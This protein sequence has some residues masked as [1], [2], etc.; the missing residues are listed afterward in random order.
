MRGP[1]N[2]GV[3][4]DAGQVSAVLL[5]ETLFGVKPLDFEKRQ[6]PEKHDSAGLAGV[7]NELLQALISRNN[8]RHAAINLGLPE[9]M[10]AFRVIELPKAVKENL[11]GALYYELNEYLP[12]LPD[13][14]YFDC[15]V[16]AEDS[17]TAMIKVLLVVAKKKLLDPL[18]D[19]GVAPVTKLTRIE[20]GSA[21]IGDFL[22]QAGAGGR[23]KPFFV[24]SASG[25]QLIFTVF[26]KGRIRHVSKISIAAGSGRGSEAAAQQMQHVIDE[27]DAAFG[28]IGTCFY[29]DGKPPEA[30]LGL[31]YRFDIETAPIET[32]KF[33]FPESGYI[34]AFGLAADPLG[35]GPNT[36]NLLPES[37]QTR[38]G[39]LGYYALYALAGSLV[40]SAGIYGGSLVYLKKNAI[41]RLDAKIV[42]MEKSVA[43]MER[44]RA[45]YEQVASRLR[46]LKDFTGGAP[47][48]QMLTE[49]SEM[50]PQ[51]TWMTEF[52]LSDNE[53]RIEGFSDSASK[54][55]G[56]LEDSPLFD[57]AR[58]LSPIRKEVNNKERFQIGVE[59]EAK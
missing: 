15:Q 25:G 45:E 53:I 5:K 47:L 34:K 28:R 41:D 55:I 12:V 9:D 29:A 49:L 39:R 21:A 14:V 16:I 30:A 46:Y 51:D 38:P 3:C 33:H 42:Q 43:S 17:E 23:A 13:E 35:A 11:K 10:V 54:L 19:I 8:V 22:V 32:G 48:I 50:I 4:I 2:I 52:R 40:I 36:L 20:I 1:V 58:F 44:V 37:L 24:M 59:I 57:N 18:L 56:L 26:E 27:I 7:I 6:I 31:L